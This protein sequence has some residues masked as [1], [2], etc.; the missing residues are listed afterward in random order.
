MPADL[1]PLG[2][3]YLPLA[4]ALGALHA[5]E[6]GHGKALASAWLVS[7]EHD[8]R[9]AV[10]LGAATTLSHTGVVIAMAFGIFWAGDLLPWEML[11]HWLGKLGGLLLLVMGLFGALR[12]G[13]DLLHGHAH[14]HGHSH[15]HAHEAGTGPAVAGESH[16]PGTSP[17]TRWWGVALLGLSNGL[18]PCPGAMT[19]LL[20]ALYMGQ[21]ALGLVTVLAYSLGLAMSLGIIG[22]LAVEA[23]RRARNLLPSDRVLLWMPL[24]SACIIAGTGVLMLTTSVS[25][26]H[27]AP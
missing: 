6:P 14:S 26:V 9:E 23:G 16:P 5:L 15:G 20:V 21:A 22:A 25:H 13:R 3:L 4:F 1:P 10:V 8:W 19:A 18:L 2:I 17:R 7:G 24:I 11:D 27:P 12:A